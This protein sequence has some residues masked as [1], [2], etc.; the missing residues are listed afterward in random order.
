VSIVLCL[1]AC[2][3]P[4]GAR[5]V[6]HS[7]VAMGSDLHVRVWTADVA[8][9]RAA[10]A[11]VFAEFDRLDALMSVWREESDVGRLNASAGGAA[12]HISPEVAEVLRAAHQVS[13][14]SDGA[15]DVTFGALSG[16]W[17][18]DHD[19]DNRIPAAADVAARLPLIDYRRVELHG[20][21]ARL[22]TAGMRVHLGG[23]GK[24]YAIDRA[25]AILRAHGLSDVLVQSGGDMYASGTRGDRAWSIGIR[26]P[27]GPADQLLATLALT[28]AAISTSGDYERFFEADGR[29]YHHILDPRT[30]QPATGTRSVTIVAPQS[31]LADAVATAV[32][33]MG[34][35]EGM[36]L[37]GRLPDV[38]AAIVTGEGELRISPGLRGRLQVAAASLPDRWPSVRSRAPGSGPA[39]GRRPPGHAS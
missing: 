33:I 35:D 28:G 24:G 22:A 20:N 29:R 36:A 39:G 5:L 15:F 30:G 11:A 31:M 7:A 16:L 13:A 1:A 38:E 2:G 3:A 9:A 32:F 10:A 12:V 19:Q 4:G 34:P 25:V 23:I 26:D 18:F 21:T 37:V 17:R 6:E 27:R 14:W 8:A